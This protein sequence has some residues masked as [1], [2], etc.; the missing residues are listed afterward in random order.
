MVEAEA[1]NR[2]GRSWCCSG[3]PAARSCWGTASS[4]HSSDSSEW[5]PWLWACK[6][7]RQ[8]WL[9][10]HASSGS[11]R[12]HEVSAPDL[13]GELSGLEE[14]CSDS[15]GGGQHETAVLQSQGAW[16]VAAGGHYRGSLPPSLWRAWCGWSQRR[17]FPNSCGC[18]S[19]SVNG[20][21][22]GREEV[23]CLQPESSALVQQC[24]SE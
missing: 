23:R 8:D 16:L 24:S 1:E 22:P 17:V 2:L 18:G 14:V 10:S 5:T 12:G 15:A 13:L 19:L 20:A 21:W 11:G 9:F 3:K 4:D 7:G 6:C